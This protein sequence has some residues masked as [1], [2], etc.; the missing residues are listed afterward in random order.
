MAPALGLEER[1]TEAVR[2]G[3]RSW[4]ASPAKPRALK[5]FQHTK[6]HPETHADQEWTGVTAQRPAALNASW[7]QQQVV[8]EQVT[9]LRTLT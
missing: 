9:V 7:L 1:G 5:H 8:Q 6:E 4:K 2:S 3:G